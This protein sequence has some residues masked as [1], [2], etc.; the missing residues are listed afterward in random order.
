MANEAPECRICFDGEDQ[1]LG[2]LF[3]P[4]LCRG[5]QAYIH[6]NCLNQWRLQ[7]AN[8]RQ[9]Y[10]CPT[11]HYN[12]RT[13]RIWYAN[14]LIHPLF[15]TILTILIITTTVITIA[16]L[17]KFFTF[18]LIGASLGRSAFALTGRLIWWSIL[19]IGFLTMIVALIKEDVRINPGDFR[20]VDS[21]I[22]DIFG[23][24]FSLSG[25]ALF[26]KNVYGVVRERTHSY[27]TQ[28]G[29]QIMEVN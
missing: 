16:L 23:Y 1:N 14:L 24:V 4:C 29:E 3:K 22:I 27:M 2:R 26:I 15:I 28:L 9:F 21:A 7:G 5:T 17:L 25:F 11:C 10:Q 8:S 6:E 12:Y 19:I 13:S 18:L 20:Y